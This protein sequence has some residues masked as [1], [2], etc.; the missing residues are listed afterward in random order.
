[1][2]TPAGFGATAA[3]A[4]ASRLASRSGDGALRE[5]FA[6]ALSVVDGAVRDVVD[7]LARARLHNDSVLVV[8]SDN[9]GMVKNGGNNYPLRGE[10]TTLWEGGYACRGGSARLRLRL[11]SSLSLS[12]RPEIALRI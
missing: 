6:G 9:G 3:S 7:A 8:V 1:M 10:K 4:L 11:L 12:S 5:T 2:Q